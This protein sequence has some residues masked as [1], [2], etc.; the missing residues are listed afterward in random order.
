MSVCGLTEQVEMHVCAKDTPPRGG[1]ACP[2]C[3]SRN[4]PSHR[5]H[6]LSL[7]SQSSQRILRYLSL[8]GAGLVDELFG[9]MLFMD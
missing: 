6:N 3:V 4:G 9:D 1:F 5:C 2:V 7:A 8:F